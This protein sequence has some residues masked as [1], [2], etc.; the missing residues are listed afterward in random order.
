[1]GTRY[2]D[3][4]IL[5]NDSEE[6]SKI[7]EQRGVPLI[8]QYNSAIMRYPTPKE[9]NTLH[10]IQHIWAVGDRYYKLAAQYYGDPTYWWVIAHYNQ[11]PTASSVNLGAV[12]YVPM[13]LTKILGYITTNR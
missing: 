8:R 2:A 6:Y 5:V 1:M 4:L 10:R 12:L 11:K 3:R 7:L 9:I 13:P